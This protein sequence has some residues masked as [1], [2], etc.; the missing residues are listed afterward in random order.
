VRGE[1]GRFLLRKSKDSQYGYGYF[2]SLVHHRRVG[3]GE[4]MKVGDKVRVVG[5]QYAGMR[6][7]T[8]EVAGPA[9]EFLYCEP[10]WIIILDKPYESVEWGPLKAVIVPWYRLEK[11]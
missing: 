4:V 11:T 10:S 1:S 2:G 6:G 7:L 3:K 9:V 5:P 8:G